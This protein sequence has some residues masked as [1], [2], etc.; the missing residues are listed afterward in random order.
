VTG[1][2]IAI[3]LLEEARKIDPTAPAEIL[4][5]MEEDAGKGPKS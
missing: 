4:K 2:D 1:S 3:L 5:D